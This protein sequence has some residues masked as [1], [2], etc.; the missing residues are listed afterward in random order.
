MRDG[1]HA[2]R[3]FEVLSFSGV[4]EVDSRGF[5]VHLGAGLGAL[6]VFYRRFAPHIP[7]YFSGPKYQRTHEE[8]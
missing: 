5:R 7:V 2:Q 8:R 3:A 1:C 6:D 4:D